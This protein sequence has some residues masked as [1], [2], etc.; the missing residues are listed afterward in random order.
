MNQNTLNILLIMAVEHKTPSMLSAKL[1]EMA[2][3]IQS[4]GRLA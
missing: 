4:E 3:F 1:T 2:H